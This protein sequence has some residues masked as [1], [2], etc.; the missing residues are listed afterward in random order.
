MQ[1]DVYS[2]PRHRDR[3]PALPPSPDDPAR[4]ACDR[5]AQELGRQ[6]RHGDG[7]RHHL[8]GVHAGV[9]ACGR[10][11]RDPRPEARRALPERV[12][13]GPASRWSPLPG[14]FTPG[15]SSSGTKVTS[16]GSR[17]AAHPEGRPWDDVALEALSEAL[18]G[19]ELR[20]G[21]DQRALALGQRP[22][23]PLL[24]PVRRCEP[25]LRAD[26]LPHRRS[27]RRERDGRSER[28]RAD[29]ALPWRLG[30]RLPDAGRRR[31][32]ASARAGRSAPGSRGSPARC[33]T[34]T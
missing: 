10:L 25:P 26:L 28:I 8:S 19:L 18:D 21:R 20:F 32:A 12:R 17:S 22:R 31:R 5:V 27:R 13:G 4:D 15:C 33:T 9:R 3:P 30:T 24:A 14:A 29:P 1:T 34:T 6:A 11:G 2:L 23:R 7:R 16:R